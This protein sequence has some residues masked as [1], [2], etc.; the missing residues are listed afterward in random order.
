MK[1]TLKI[2]TNNI[3]TY[4]SLTVHTYLIS[5]Y[6]KN[7]P[8]VIYLMYNTHTYIYIYVLIYIAYAYIVALIA[9]TKEMKCA[10]Y[11]L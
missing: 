9:N 2:Y 10:S 4:K 1:H 7:N 6:N 3:R 11:L 5:K 8:L